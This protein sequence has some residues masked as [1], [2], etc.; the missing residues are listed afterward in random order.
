M[1]PAR[2]GIEPIG[3]L[4]AVR[5]I[6]SAPDC[7]GTIASELNIT[8]LLE[9]IWV[10]RTFNLVVSVNPLIIFRDEE[11]FTDEQA[12]TSTVVIFRTTA[13]GERGRT[14]KKCQNMFHGLC[15]LEFQTHLDEKRIDRGF[16]VVGTAVIGFGELNR[17]MLE[18]KPEIEP[19]V[20]ESEAVL[21]VKTALEPGFPG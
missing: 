2:R 6:E 12:G 7:S 4:F 3:E 14:E 13:S 19:P 16:L 18:S 21:A 8:T 10:V 20:V 9:L 11:P 17:L 5:F 1:K 15:K